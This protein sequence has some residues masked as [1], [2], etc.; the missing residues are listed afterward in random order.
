[1]KEITRRAAIGMSALAVAELILPKSLAIASEAVPVTEEDISSCLIT[2]NPTIDEHNKEVALL[3]DEAVS[4]AKAEGSEI[5]TVT[6]PEMIYTE[7]S[8]A[9]STHVVSTNVSDFDDGGPWIN[10]NYYLSAMYDIN[11]NWV[12]NFRNHTAT[13]TY[14]M[15]SPSIQV[16]GYTQ[17]VLDG[18]R[19]F[20]IR[21]TLS[22]TCYVAGVARSAQWQAYSEW[23]S[24][25]SAYLY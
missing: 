5:I 3:W 16:L 18:G 24:S 19:T 15:Y 23:S 14:G 20:A 22:V 7:P 13:V 12:T 1:M 4:K 2:G 25:G 9:R 17:T 21:T 6:N 10:I 11:G 8:L